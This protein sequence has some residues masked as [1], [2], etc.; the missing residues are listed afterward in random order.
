MSHRAPPNSPLL[1]T[2]VEKL[3]P[4]Q[5]NKETQNR[6]SAQSHCPLFWRWRGHCVVKWKTTEHS[7]GATSLGRSWTSRLRGT[8]V[9]EVG[10]RTLWEGAESAGG[11]QPLTAGGPDGGVHPPSRSRARRP[12]LPYLRLSTAAEGQT[13]TPQFQA[14]AAA[15]SSSCANAVAAAAST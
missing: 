2:D 8:E 4:K 14:A 15:T 13:Q 7:F 10:P 5:E 11:R 12:H 3:R 9:T 6:C 1:W